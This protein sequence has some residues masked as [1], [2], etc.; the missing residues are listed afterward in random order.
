MECYCLDFMRDGRSIASGWSDG[1]VRAFLPQSGKLLYAISDAHRNGVTALATTSDCGRIVTGGMEGEVRVWRIGRQ[2]QTMDVSLKE[3][4]GQVWCVRIKAD[5]SQAVTASS[6]GSCIVWDLSSKTR[7]L[8]LFESTMFKSLVYH[9]DESQLLTTGSDRKIAYW[10]TFD[11]QAIRVLEASDEGE[12]TT[13][14]MSA[15]GSHYVSGGQDRLLKLWDYDEGICKYLGIGHSGTISS[16]AIAPDQTFIVS[17]GTEGA[18]LIWTVPP[19]V[20][21]KCHEPVS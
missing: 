13:L 3:H 18:I 10:D 9:P 21:E 16:A 12:L 1:K 6:D 20:V 19:E 8:C 5:D 14:S 7:S 11:G 17:V 4:R 2:T 15:S